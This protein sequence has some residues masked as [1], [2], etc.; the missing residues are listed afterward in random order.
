[1]A[2]VTEPSGSS[3]ASS[4]VG[5]ARVAD[6]VAGRVTVR[7]PSSPA[8]TNAPLWLTVTVT[9]RGAGGAGWAEMTYSTSPPSVP[10]PAARVML[11]SG[12]LGVTTGGLP[13]TSVCP[14]M[15]SVLMSLRSVL[16]QGTSPAPSGARFADLNE[17]TM[18]PLRA[19]SQS[20]VRLTSFGTRSQT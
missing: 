7:R 19:H 12:S 8:A 9:S 6:P 14:G 5:M 18:Q 2:S 20:S 10:L 15:N 13:P 17:A 3:A 1:M 4:M 16:V 11:T